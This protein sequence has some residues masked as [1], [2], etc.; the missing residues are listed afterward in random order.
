MSNM[1]RKIAPQSQPD[2]VRTG[3]HDVNGRQWSRP[4]LVRIDPDSPKAARA[5]AALE[6]RQQR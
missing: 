3:L 5:R 4:E 2:C 6:M 1:D